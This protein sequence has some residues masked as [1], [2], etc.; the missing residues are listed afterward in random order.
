[1]FTLSQLLVAK[2]LLNPT[3]VHESKSDVSLP[4]TEVIPQVVHLAPAL[5]TMEPGDIQTLITPKPPRPTSCSPSN[6]SDG[7]THANL[8]PEKPSINGLSLPERN[9]LRRRY[10]KDMVRFVEQHGTISTEPCGPCL[11]TNTECIRHPVLSRCARCFRGHDVCEMWDD[12]VLSSGR[13]RLN[14][15]P[16]SSKKGGKV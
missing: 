2:L 6:D 5:Q 15:L 1:V 10:E 11:R 14:R 8:P 4:M 16:K 3:S 7:Y 13:R 12:S 9:D